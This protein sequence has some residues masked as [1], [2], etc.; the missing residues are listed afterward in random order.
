MQQDDRTLEQVLED[1]C[2]TCPLFHDFC[3]PMF[4]NPNYFGSSMCEFEDKNI[5]IIDYYKKINKRLN[6]FE[7]AEDRRIENEKKL[8]EKNALIARKRMESYYCVYDENKE[9]KRLKK[10]INN[11]NKLIDFATS[12]TNAVNFANKVFGYREVPKPNL[13]PLRLE[14]EQ[15]QIKIDELNKIKKEKLKKLR[16]E[17]IK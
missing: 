6:D 16:K 3:E 2:D 11:N 8:K 4:S 12:R 10:L 7:D 9:I 15:L 5:N 1:G 13:E 17:R 14:N